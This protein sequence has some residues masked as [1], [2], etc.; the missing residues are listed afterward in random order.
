MG[1]GAVRVILLATLGLSGAIA[2]VVLAQDVPTPPRTLADL[3][4]GEGWQEL[5][6]PSQEGL[7]ARAWSDPA[8]GSH[9]LSLLLTIPAT[10]KIDPLAASFAKTL[11][12]KNLVMSDLQGQ[13]DR[14]RLAL[15][16]D[17]LTGIGDLQLHRQAP[18]TGPSWATLTT[19]YW[20]DREPEMS[21]AS[22]MR[23]L[24]SAPGIGIQR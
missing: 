22:C 23:I 3:A 16:G 14:R 11:K 15:A 4:P 12:A 17:N 18:T 21:R 19:C 20:N 8:A 10:A 9:V 2:G 7:E 5:Q 1:C 24:G 6:V 13:G